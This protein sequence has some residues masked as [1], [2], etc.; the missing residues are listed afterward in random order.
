MQQELTETS[1]HVYSTG[2]SPSPAHTSQHGFPYPQPDNSSIG[3]PRLRSRGS[4]QSV[5]V[6][7]TAASDDFEFDEL[8][9][10]LRRLSHSSHRSTGKG[11][12]AVAGQRIVEYENAL[13]PSTPKQ[14]GFKVIRRAQSPSEGV[15]LTDFPNGTFLS[16]EA[17]IGP[18]ANN[19]LKR[20]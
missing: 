11:R 16:L 14:L 9:E 18:C 2:S 3:D 13:T 20:F 7:G 1:Y 8:E 5:S 12:T 6:T 4:S 19:F 17:S 15:Q 10:R